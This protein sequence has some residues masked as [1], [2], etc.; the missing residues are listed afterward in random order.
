MTSWPGYD[1][2]DD[3]LL[4]VGPTDHG[5]S[6]GT[7]DIDSDDM[8]NELLEAAALRIQSALRRRQ[9]E[10]KK[11]RAHD[12]QDEPWASARAPSAHTPSRIVACMLV[13]L[14]LV[15]LPSWHLL[16]AG[17]QPRVSSEG[18]SP[19]L[20]LPYPAL[21]RAVEDGKVFSVELAEQRGDD[22]HDAWRLVAAT[23]ADGHHAAGS[24]AY[25][26]PAYSLSSLLSILRAQGGV[27][28]PGTV[29][30]PPPPAATP[31]V[32]LA[33]WLMAPSVAP[34]DPTTS[35]IALGTP[36]APP[37]LAYSYYLV[38]IGLPLLA[39]AL[40]AWLLL[41][42][43]RLILALGRAGLA[44]VPRRAPPRPP[45][46]KEEEAAGAAA[47]NRT[48]ATH[49]AAGAHA[50]LVHS[51]LVRTQQDGVALSYNRFR[52]HCARRGLTRKEES[53]LWAQYK[54]LAGVRG[55]ARK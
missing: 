12:K 47:P 27:K 21:L 55:A 5:S 43:T 44:A 50:A 37:P 4:V 14:G 39:V 46:I 38:Y 13:C 20:L 33:S 8:V 30:L 6:Q 42:L 24:S 35:L 16:S 19:P 10:T 32:M 22:T 15:L 34:R 2:V 1:V 45:P 18:A 54:G 29:A 48:H 41:Q 53:A 3:W 25:S 28:L 17:S 52:T 49:K 23:G 36:D 7:S 11:K 26:V 9:Q 40:A 51:A 31:P